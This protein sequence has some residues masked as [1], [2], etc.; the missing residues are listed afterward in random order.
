MNS[1]GFE[2]GSLHPDITTTY[3]SL[4]GLVSGS[5]LDR[6]IFFSLHETYETTQ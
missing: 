5:N 6:L 4:S 3:H 2:P 1:A